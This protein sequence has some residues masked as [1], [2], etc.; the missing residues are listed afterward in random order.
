MM[1]LEI[2]SSTSVSSFLIEVRAEPA[3][4]FTAQL[5]GA[6]DLHATAATREEAMDELRA[7]LRQRL[8]SGSLVWLEVPRENPL[9]RWFGHAKD[10]PTFPE[11]LEEIRKFREEM[12]R[13]DDTGSGSS[14]CSDT[15]LT[16]TT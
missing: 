6:A 8:D 7:L 9:M 15:S 11:Y 16:P 4:R 14:E 12:D 2:P 1:N 5:I 10:D 3:G 13:R